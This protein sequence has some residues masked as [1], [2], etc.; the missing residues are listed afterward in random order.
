MIQQCINQ[1]INILEENKEILDICSQEMHNKILKRNTFSLNDLYYITESFVRTYSPYKEK[2]NIL[3][4]LIY[5]ELCL[6]I[7]NNKNTA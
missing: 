2:Y 3:Y 4:E 6:Y 5:E 7:N 1:W